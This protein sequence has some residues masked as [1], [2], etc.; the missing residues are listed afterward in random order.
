[1]ANTFLHAQGINVGKSLVEKDMA[2]TAR[3][4]MAKAET[5]GLRDHP[6]GRCHRGVPLRGQR[7]LA[8]LWRRRHPG[9][10]HDPRHR[11]AIDGARQGRDRRRRARWSGTGRS[12]R[13]SC[14]R[15]SGRR[16]RS[17]RYAAERTKAGKIS[18]SGRRRRHGRGAE[19]GRR[20]RQIYLCVHSRRR[21]PG[22]DGGQAL[23]RR[24]GVEAKMTPKA[25]PG[26]RRVQR[27]ETRDLYR[28]RG[29]SAMNLAE[30]N[31]IARSHGRARQ[32]HPGRRRVHR[33]DQEA[34]R[35][36]QRGMHRG[37]PPRLS[38]DAVPLRPR[39]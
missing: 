2:D 25:S 22:M 31:K 24:R 1:M 13:S 5:E 20:C 29:E 3:R 9:G 10:R 33:H 34:L 12:A 6:A 8:R 19:H 37:Q 26:A 4:I 36:H 18:L 32:G 21:L 16:S 7:A 35:R 30:L 39:A 38:R 15:S 14:R 27:A 11:P 17:A 28:H 23:A